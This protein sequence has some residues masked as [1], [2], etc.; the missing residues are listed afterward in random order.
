AIA[1]IGEM[2][3]M[4]GICGG[5]NEIRRMLQESENEDVDE[6]DLELFD[7]SDDKAAQSTTDKQLS[8]HSANFA[9]EII[10]ESDA[11]DCG[12]RYI[13]NLLRSSG[14]LVSRASRA[15]RAL[16]NEKAEGNH[17]DWLFTKHDLEKNL[18]WGLEFSLCERAGSITDNGKKVTSDSVKVQKLLR[19]MHSSLMDHI[20][21]LGGGLTQQMLRASTKLVMPGFISNCF[22]LRVFLLVYIGGNFYASMELARLDIP[23]THKE[24]KNIVKI[25][26]VMLQATNV[27]RSTINRFKRMKQKAEKDKL[28]VQKIIPFERTEEERTPKKP[29]NNRKR[30]ALSAINF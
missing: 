21:T 22:E 2:L 26:E 3:E 5:I 10:Q 6:S 20:K 12:V 14:E 11:E 13:M 15:R 19:D 17:I 16:A 28:S 30:Q 7:D 4:D 18:S 25:G 24:L 23:T 1:K 9:M 27:L 29:K 8:L